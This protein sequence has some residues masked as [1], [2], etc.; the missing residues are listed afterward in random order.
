MASIIDIAR[1][2]N[3]SKSTVSRV[4]TNSGYVKPE[5]RDKIVTVM[6]EVGFRPNVFASGMRTN[7]S[8]SIG[9]LYP[10]LLNP[11][12][13][14]WYAVVDRISR[15]CGYLNYICITDPKG[16]TEEQRIDDLLARRIDGILF[17]SYRKN[18]VFLNKLRT[19][20][21]QTPIVFCD[22]MFRNEGVSCVYA[23]GKTGTYDALFHL[24]STGKKRIAYIK[25]KRDYQVVDFRYQGYCEALTAAGLPFDEEL[26]YE[27]EFKMEC[28]IRAAEKFMKLANPA[29]AIMASTDFMAFGALDYLRKNNIQI[30]EQ[31]AVFGFDNLNMSQNTVPP[32]ST[33]VMPILE[34]AENAINTLIL[35]MSEKHEKPI[36]HVVKCEL[37]I[38]Q[39]SQII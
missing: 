39:S 11:F 5:T 3:V 31:V 36:E 22:S 14:E 9:I 16:E 24:V 18:P 6:K 1:L 4:I 25:S 23:D 37:K 15:S 35:L 7:R 10:D 33:V 32:L 28:G 26:I 17:F 27:G 20:S 12:F 30:P 2:A 34:V 29:D 19:I 8:Y 13:A 21:V 38:R